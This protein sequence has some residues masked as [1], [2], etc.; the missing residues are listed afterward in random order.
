M[1]TYKFNADYT[2]GIS[3]ASTNAKNSDAANHHDPDFRLQSLAL[4]ATGETPLERG[5]PQDRGDGEVGQVV[6][7]LVGADAPPEFRI[8]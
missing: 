1:A 8:D 3:A 4:Q 5:P 2:E 6:Q 7:K